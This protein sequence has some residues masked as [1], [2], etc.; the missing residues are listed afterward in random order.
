[1]AS[2]KKNFIY[3]FLLNISRIV[4][5]LITTPYVSRVLEPEGIG[6][7]HFSATFAGYFALVA[8]LGVPTYG[9]REVAKLKNSTREMSLLISQLLTIVAVSTFFTSII[10]FISLLGI[11]QLRTDFLLFFLSGF[12]IY[13]SPFQTTWFYQ[14][15]EEFNFITIRTLIIKS[16]SV[17]CLFLFVT[18]KDDLITYVI[19]SA[20]G[21][22]LADIWNFWK[23][24]SKDI[25][26]MLTFKGLKPHMRPIV[27][28]FAS[29]VAIS[30]YT[31]LDTLM[32]GFISDYSEV[33][34]YGNAIMMSKIFL[35]FVTS[36]SVVSIPRF[37]S[38]IH[39]GDIYNANLLA[40]RSFSF[41]GLLSFPLT[42]GI[43][44]IAPVLIPWFFGD[45]YLGAIL[46]LEI[47]SF[48]NVIMGFSNI[49]GLQILVGMGKDKCFLT[50]ILFGAISNFIMNCIFIPLYGAVGASISSIVAEFL[51]TISMV[52]FVYKVTPVKID[53][54]LDLFKSLIGSLLFFLLLAI[55]PELDN[56][57]VY[58]SSFII[59][60]AVVY[61]LSQ[62]ILRHKLSLELLHTTKGYI[63]NLDKIWIRE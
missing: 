60:S 27:L 52:Y 19:I 40:N 58:L 8:L 13:L 14:G 23:M 59:V 17:I 49:L 21:T 12:C 47:L 15:I 46:P 29:S 55:F 61:S 57:V 42:I 62:I 63:R 26:I 48:L 10:Y 20:L 16:L 51:V 35:T 30:I 3:N 56:G 2:I 31:V 11:S 38:Y 50:C 37:T 43:I 1:M 32:L 41:A 25:K 44:C 7:Y 34:Y 33:G 39:E 18:Q 6:L 53:V 45:K 54:K 36:L 24:K 4:F 9:V 22:I 5:P 28:L